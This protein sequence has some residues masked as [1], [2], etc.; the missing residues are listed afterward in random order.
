MASFTRI[1]NSL[2]GGPKGNVG[3]FRHAARIFGDNLYRLA[4]RTKFLHYVYFEIDA[5]AHQAASFSARK[6]D[7]EM[8]FLV[9]RAD[10]PKL[11]F[12][13]VTKN[14]YNRKKIVYKQINYEPITLTFHDDNSGIMHSLYSLYY[15]YYVR[16]HLNKE[17]DYELGNDYA[18]AG[19]RYNMDIDIQVNL[20]KRISLYTLSRR[21][22]NEYRILAPRIK[23]WSHG[24]L[25]TYGSAD[26]IENTMTLEYEAVTYNTGTVVQGT[27]DGFASLSYDNIQSPLT[28]GGGGLRGIAQGLGLG[29]LS[30]IESAMGGSLSL[31]NIKERP[32]TFIASALGAVNNYQKFNEGAQVGVGGVVGALRSP[33]AVAGAVS[34]AGGALAGAAFPKDKS[35]VAS[36]ITAIAT[37]KIVNAVSSTNSFGST[38]GGSGGKPPTGP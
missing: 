19:G 24:D 26:T 17:F 34:L 14:Q 33:A 3:D 28:L 5:S 7:K 32:G 31:K 29:V 18:K 1:L 15:G 6:A 36:L 2:P 37:P 30:D 27:P 16:D 38:F 20:F 13:S 10:L 21:R 12:D 35:G 22:F 8:S 25:D 23:S 9:K 11:N 4:P